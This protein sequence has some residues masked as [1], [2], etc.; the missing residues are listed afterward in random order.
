M[1]LAATPFML[2]LLASAPVKGEVLTSKGKA[3]TYVHVRTGAEGCGWE[4]A[5]ECPLGKPS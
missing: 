4:A 5:P 1:K 3:E 2:L